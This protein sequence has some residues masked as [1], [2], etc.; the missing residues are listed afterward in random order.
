MNT[1][2]TDPSNRA[3]VSG[4]W[5]RSWTHFR[6]DRRSPRYCHVMFDHPPINITATTVAEFSDLAGLI[7]HD[8]DLN[9]VVFDSANRDFY[10]AHYDLENDPSRCA[11]LGDGP[12]GLPASIDV[13]G[14]SGSCPGGQ[15][16]LDLGARPRRG[17]RFGARL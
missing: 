1:I 3:R 8:P 6:I 16:R 13:L 15:H 7:E 14:P 2:E 11:A 10:L 4:G 17:K 5:S 12:T 9:V